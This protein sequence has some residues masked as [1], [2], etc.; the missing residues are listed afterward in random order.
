MRRTTFFA[1]ILWCVPIVVVNAQSAPKA[2]LEIAFTGIRKEIG[3]I[4]IGI[5]S[6]PDG[7]PRKPQMELNWKKTRI[8]D[9]VFTAKIEGMDYGTYAISVLDDENSDLEM[10]MF[11]GIP[12]EGYGFSNNPSVGLSTPKFEECAFVLDKP[13]VKISIDLRYTMKGR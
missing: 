6:S 8:E 10:E 12:R 3:L 5:N 13:F 1:M 2:T 11:L 9:G 4:A 7:W